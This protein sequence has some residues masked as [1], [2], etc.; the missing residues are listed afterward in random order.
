MDNPFQDR[1]NLPWRSDVLGGVSMQRA[2]VQVVTFDDF[3][4]ARLAELTKFGHA[5]TGDEHRGADLVQD[6]LVRVLPR[7]DR[8]R[9]R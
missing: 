1:P 4:R 2:Q 3:V 8:I 5:L 9:V 6:A 7:W